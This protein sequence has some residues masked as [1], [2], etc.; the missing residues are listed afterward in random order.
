MSIPSSSELVAT[1]AGDA[2]GLQVLL[3]LDPLLAGDAAVMGPDQL[4]AGQLVQALGEAL[5]QP[6][7]VREDDRATGGSGSARGSAD[8]SPAR[9]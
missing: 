1:I 9:C 8:G 2:A 3:D 7:A 5:R 4:L 6:P